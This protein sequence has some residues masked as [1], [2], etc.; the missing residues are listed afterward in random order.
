[1][2]ENGLQTFAMH[3]D[4]ARFRSTVEAMNLDLEAVTSDMQGAGVEEVDPETAARRYLAALLSEP[5]APGLLAGAVDFQVLKTETVALTGTKVV[6]FAQH[7]R[8]IAVY[9]SL[10]TVELDAD[11]T[12]LAIHTALGEP[13]DVDPVA[14][15]SPAQAL[16]VIGD[17]GATEEP[18]KLYYYF[19]NQTTPPRWRRGSRGDGFA[20]CP[21]IARSRRLDGPSC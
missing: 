7:Y 4:D 3:G 10:V 19:D 13:A 9:G 21:C 6:K 14:T 5:G 17:D 18:P 12:L 1:M 15:I 16:A 11:N 8:R 20:S 2:T